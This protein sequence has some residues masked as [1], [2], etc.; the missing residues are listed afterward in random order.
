MLDQHQPW[1]VINTAGWVRVDDAEGEADACLRANADGAAVLAE[2]CAARGI[3]FTTFS[4]DLVFD[5]RQPGGYGEDDTP[6]PAQ[7]L[8]PQQGG[9]GGAHRRGQPGSADRADC[10][11]LLAA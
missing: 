11:V 8:W 6:S 7:R 2:Q 5:G 1:A 4:S 10:S 3:H 9:S